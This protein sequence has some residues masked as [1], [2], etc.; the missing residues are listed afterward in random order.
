MGSTPPIRNPFLNLSSIS[1]SQT[2]IA[3]RMTDPPSPRG[4]VLA[5]ANRETAPRPGHGLARGGSEGS[6]P[7]G[8][9]CPSTHP[10]V[11]SLQGRTVRL[12]LG[13][14]TASQGGVPGVPRLA[15]GGCRT[16]T[17]AFES[18]IPLLQTFP[19]PRATAADRIAAEAFRLRL[20]AF[21][22]ATN[23]LFDVEPMEQSG[24]GHVHVEIDCP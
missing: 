6:G 3:R 13:L 18:P 19:F 12:H 21:V 9:S 8:I 15:Q 20:S 24:V 11:S 23:T 7:C 16:W 22:R 1:R 14:G 10:I 17:R 2:E 4:L 5:R